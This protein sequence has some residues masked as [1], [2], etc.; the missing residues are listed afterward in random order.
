MPQFSCFAAKF[1][2]RLEEKAFFKGL[3]SVKFTAHT[4]QLLAQFKLFS[5]STTK[6]LVT[7]GHEFCNYPHDQSQWLR[8]AKGKDR[9]EFMTE[10]GFVPPEWVYRASGL[11]FR[12]GDRWSVWSKSLLNA[13]KLL[14]K[15]RGIPVMLIRGLK[16]LAKCPLIRPSLRG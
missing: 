16:M 10:N 6:I 15:S 5:R 9:S 3:A 1:L 14:H 12:E 2:T 7:L 11:A 8:F 13:N 4:D